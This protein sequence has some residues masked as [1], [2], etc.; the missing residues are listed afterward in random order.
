MNEGLAYERELFLQ[1]MQSEQRSA[2]TYVFQAERALR[3]EPV[4]GGAQPRP[5]SRIGIVGAGTMGAGIAIAALAAGYRVNLIDNNAEM[6][7]KGKARI[8]S[9][10]ERDVEKGRLARSL[11]DDRIAALKCSQD[12]GALH[13]CDLIIEAIVENMGVKQALFGKLD[14]VAKD[15]AVLATNTSYLDVKQIAAATRRPADIVGMHFF[16]PANIMPLLEVI[17]PA[18]ASDDALAT[19][20]S[21][22]KAM[23]KMCIPARVGDGFIGNRIFK[24]YR[25]KAEML[26]EDGALPH[27]VDAAARDFGFAMGPLEVSDLAGLDIGW[28]NRRREDATRD[29]DKR[30]VVLADL[31]YEQGRMGQKTGKGWYLYADG[32]REPLRDPEVEALILA[33]SEANGI[34]RQ[35]FTM[36]DIQQQLLAAM[37]AEG[38][39]LLHE[40]VALRSSDIDLVMIN[41]YG[42]PSHRGGPMYLAQQTAI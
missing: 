38:K 25:E 33:Q 4:Y 26:V 18:A 16:S 6:L 42:F 40:G 19:A 39:A 41:G 30:Y 14:R 37:M 34:T 10:F 1:C 13:N 7:T 17:C 23:G 21:V 24:V 28:A 2:L 15:G 8:F 11:A 36:A 35:T 5:V 20:F 31:L 22:G 12:I 32:S 29:P 27:E 9:S 3:S